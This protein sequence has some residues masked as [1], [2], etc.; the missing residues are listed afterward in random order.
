MPQLGAGD[1]YGADTLYGL[2]G[3]SQF[4]QV[5]ETLSF[6]N[7]LSKSHGRHAFKMGYEVLRWRLNRYDLGT[8]S[9]V[10]S[11]TGMTAGLQADGL[12]ATVPNTGNTFAGFLFGSVRQATFSIELVSW[13]PRSSMHSFY[14]QDDYKVTPTLTANLGLRYSNES[15][16]N[17]KYSQMS[18]FDPL[19]IAD[20]RA[21]RSAPHLPGQP[22]SRPGNLRRPAQRHGGFSGANFGSRGSEWWDPNLH[23]PY[24]MNWHLSTQYELTSN[25]LLEVSYQASAGVGL[26]ER[27]EINTFPIDFAANDPALRSRVFAAAQNFRPFPHFGSVRMR[28]Y[29]GHSKFHSR[30]IKL[31][32]RF[33]RSFF[34]TTFYTLSKGLDSQDNDNDGSGVAPIQNRGLEKGRAGF[35]RNHRYIG[36]ITW[37]L[38]FGFAGSPFNYYDG[39]AG[40]RRPNLVSR[41]VLR[42]GWREMGGDRFNKENINPIIDINH[43]AYPAAFSVGNAGRGITTGT[44][45]LWSQVSASKNIPIGERRNFQI[46]WDFQN[47]LKNY[48]FNT[49]DTTVN[50][51]RPREFG[52]VTSDPRTASL[53]GQPLM[54]LTLQLSW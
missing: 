52:K 31:E 39:F 5:N 27:W 11:F 20:V 51:A 42:D 48:N 7:D 49:P 17:T 54:N 23:S 46:R 26:K 19:G 15:P 35:D 33:S 43:F 4:R 53:G 25:Y 45:L 24:V 16:F 30:T 29:F 38:P 47:A 8:P 40:N 41:P 2:T 6:R 22:G 34:F 1:C 12:G 36:T 32:K 3:G 37:E 13:L 50:F 44:R 14:F 21:G 9:G 28:S 10:F 18:N